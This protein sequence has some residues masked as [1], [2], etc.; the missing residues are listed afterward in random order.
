MLVAVHISDGVLAWPWQVGGFVGTAVLL[1]LGSWRL[2]EE[3]IPRIAVLASGFFVA[4]LIRVPTPG[5]SVHLILNG[6]VGVV[7]GWRAGLAIFTGL[8]LQALLFNHGGLGSLGVNAVVMTLPA[9]AA[10][11]AWR[12][13]GVHPLLGRAR[14][15]WGVGFVLG[16]LT[17]AA[18]ALLNAMVLLL[19][20]IE[21]WDALAYTV[22][23]L[24][25]PVAAIE[26]VILGATVSFLARVK[27]E[28]IG[29]QRPAS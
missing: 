13:P 15:R 9:L 28:M 24:H 22:L 26:G 4:S 19:G 7:L 27:P 8:V 12:I 10:A 21:Q 25:L 11:S 6:L 2:R 16:V 20:G 29:L 14:W 18:T 23:F 17:V 5:V 3:E 1:A